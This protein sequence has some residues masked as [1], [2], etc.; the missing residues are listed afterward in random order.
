LLFV[1][2]LLEKQYVTGVIHMKRKVVQ[3]GP[4]TLIISLPSNWIKQN[5]VKRGDELD[6]GEQDAMLV[7]ESGS[8]VSTR[9][10]T[11]NIST[12]DPYLVKTFL[13]RIY[14]K[15][16]DRAYIVHNNPL[17]LKKIQ[18]KTLEL[19]GYEII[20]QNNKYCMIQSISSHIE[21]DFDNSLKKAFTITKQMLE[22]AI[23]AY[24]DK[25]DAALE[26][27]RI[28]DFEV[29]RSCYFCLRQINKEQY[30]GT[31][32]TQQSHI[33]YSI[34]ESLEHLG[35]DMVRLGAYLSGAN[36]RHPDITKMMQLL[37]NQLDSV[38]SYYYDSTTDKANKAHGL[39]IEL[40]ASMND[41]GKAKMSSRDL[42]SAHAIRSASCEL[43]YLT[44]SRLD[45]QKNTDTV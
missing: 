35:D 29:N 30:I 7:I 39:F 21:L 5:N 15:G 20:E 14:Q 24:E 32:Q 13:A 11:Q 16:Y 28:M 38:Y 42:M 9:S 8:N 1:I 26:G 34:I 31:E 27:L 2:L 43:Y 19:I 12:L 37:L 4:S 23:K 22:I 36:K 40:S 45:F 44:V 41:I 25:N 18:E 6:V 17:L 10:M 33:L 3:H